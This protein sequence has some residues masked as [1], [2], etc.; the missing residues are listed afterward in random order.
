MTK[1]QGK[2]NCT[3]SILPGFCQKYSLWLES[4]CDDTLTSPFYVLTALRCC[5]TG[6]NNHKL[7]HHSPWQLCKWHA[8][9][10]CHKLHFR[11]HFIYIGIF[12]L[13]TY[14]LKVDGEEW[15]EKER[16]FLVLV[17]SPKS[18]MGLGLL[19]VMG[20]QGLAPS[21]DAS[22]DVHSKKLETKAEPGSEPGQSIIGCRHYKPCLSCRAQTPAPVFLL[23]E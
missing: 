12:L 22:Q 23:T 3:L 11:K 10:H 2:E 5:S 14:F 4:R 19:W 13:C 6:L 1:I 9:L 20:T 17:H 15:G 21:P 8:F 18:L 16:I 7:L